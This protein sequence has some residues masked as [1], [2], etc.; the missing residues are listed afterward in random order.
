MELPVDFGAV[1][2]G[3]FFDPTTAAALEDDVGDHSGGELYSGD[4]LFAHPG[5]VRSAA[6]TLRQ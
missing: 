6:R 5:A 2:F 3:R 1:V 4:D